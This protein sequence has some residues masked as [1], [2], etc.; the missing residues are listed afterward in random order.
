MADACLNEDKANVFQQRAAGSKS[1]RSASKRT[2]SAL[3]GGRKGGR[4]RLEPTA[5][6]GMPVYACGTLVAS[7]R[8]GAGKICAGPAF[9]GWFGLTRETGGRHDSRFVSYSDC[10]ISTII[11]W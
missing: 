1:G 11:K 2:G 3:S 6:W 4:T 9:I 10:D 7:D 5:I 8:A